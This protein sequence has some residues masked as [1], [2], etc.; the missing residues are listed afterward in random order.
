MNLEEEGFTTTVLCSEVL[1]TT[2]ISYQDARKIKKYLKS[3]KSPVVTIT[4]I[5][6]LVGVDAPPCVAS[7]SSRGPISKFSPNLIKPDIIAPGVNIV[8]ASLDASKFVVMSGTSMA[9]P[10][11][12]GL[13]ALLKEAHPEWSP[14]MIKSALMTTSDMLNSSG[15]PIL[16]QQKENAQILS[17]GCGHVNP[18]KMFNPGL[19]YDIHPDDYIGYF[20]GL[21]YGRKR[22]SK[23]VGMNHITQS[24][25]IDAAELN[26]PSLMFKLQVGEKRTFKRVVT[27]VGEANSTYVLI[28]NSLPQGVML[29]VQPN[30]LQFSR[31]NE[32]TSYNMS[33]TRQDEVEEGVKAGEG[34]ITW[35]SSK[36][37]VR[38]PFLIEFD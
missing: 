26:L 25:E 10:M 32:K 12:T 8:G 38:T 33:F 14:A 4:E 5:H 28:V 29:N 36:H 6:T 24:Q 18:L 37:S 13:A 9:C 20:F 1:P 11:V 27:N 31:L 7:F 21:G 16:D 34:S 17:L 35:M 30:K 2:S 19:V 23:I 15:E 22:V 3:T